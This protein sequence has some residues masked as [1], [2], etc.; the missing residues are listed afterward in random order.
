MTRLY[1][2]TTTVTPAKSKAE[3]ES[4][5]RRYGAD[6]FMYG[7]SWANVVVGFRYSPY[8][9]RFVVPMLPLESFS[10]TPAGRR[11]YSA[12]ARLEAHA[13]DERRRWRSLLL[14]IKAKLDV[15]ATGI[16]TFEQEFLPYIVLPSGQTVSQWMVPQLKDA[17]ASGSM[18][19]EMPL[20]LPAPRRDAKKDG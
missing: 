17:I 7:C 10:T 1:A 13:Q 12:K 16:A 3:I 19:D 8:L 5:L 2:N 20:G 18:P 9:I 15:V 14:A 4:V 11:R 6:Q